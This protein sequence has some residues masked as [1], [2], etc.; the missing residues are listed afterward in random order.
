MLDRLAHVTYRRRW[1]VLAIWVV[2]LVGMSILGSKFAGVNKVEFN[3]PA[4]D[5][6]KAFDLLKSAGTG[7]DNAHWLPSPDR[8]IACHYEGDALVV[9]RFGKPWRS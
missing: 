1:L 9:M 5:S 4:S 6:Q 8:V 3:L 2:L 7:D